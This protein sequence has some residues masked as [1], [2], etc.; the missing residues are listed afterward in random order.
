MTLDYGVWSSR[1]TLYPLYASLASLGCP[2][3]LVGPTLPPAPHLPRT[4]PHPQETVLRVK[5]SGKKCLEL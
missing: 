3:S 1:P 2:G 5:Q 4:S